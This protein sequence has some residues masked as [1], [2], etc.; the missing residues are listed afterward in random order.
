M[1]PTYSPHVIECQEKKEIRGNQSVIILIII[2][3]HLQC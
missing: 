2:W 1:L 3:E